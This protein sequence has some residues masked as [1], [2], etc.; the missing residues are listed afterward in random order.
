MIK[1]LQKHGAPRAEPVAPYFTPQWGDIPATRCGIPPRPKAV[2]YC[3]RDEIILPVEQGFSLAATLRGCP[4]KFP[5][6]VRKGDFVCSYK[7]VTHRIIFIN[8]PDG[9]SQQTRYR[10]DSDLGTGF[11]ILPKGNGIRHNHFFNGGLFKH[12]NRPA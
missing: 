12:L 5:L 2:V 3:C 1:L 6:P 4:T 8:P 11:G 10:K 7:Q 9:F